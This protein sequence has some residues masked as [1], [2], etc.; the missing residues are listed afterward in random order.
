MPRSYGLACLPPVLLC[1]QLPRRERFFRSATTPVATPRAG[2]RTR[3]AWSRPRARTVPRRARRATR[4]G[5]ATRR[6]SNPKRVEA[7]TGAHGSAPGSCR[8]ARGAH[9]SNTAARVA[10]GGATPPPPPPPYPSCRQQQTARDSTARADDGTET[11]ARGK[12]N[13]AR[14]GRGRRELSPAHLGDAGR[15]ARAARGRR[16]RRARVA[17]RRAS[18]RRSA[19]PKTSVLRARVDDFDAASAEGD[20]ERYPNGLAAAVRA[21]R[22]SVWPSEKPRPVTNRACRSFLG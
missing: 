15:C 3:S 2:I 17:R 12:K 1:A 5:H 7:S 16:A 10:G 18:G 9:L 4:R 22:R 8:D 11:P 19:G 21:S 6:D 20:D 14:G 13:A